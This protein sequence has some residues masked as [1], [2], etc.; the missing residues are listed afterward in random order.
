MIHQKERMDLFRILWNPTFLLLY[1]SGHCWIQKSRKRTQ[2]FH[3]EALAI[4][5][6]HLSVGVPACLEDRPTTCKW[7]VT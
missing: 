2:P 3:G 5:A 6:V 1:Y 7:L 4:V